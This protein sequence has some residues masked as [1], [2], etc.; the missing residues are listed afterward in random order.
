MVLLRRLEHWPS[1]EGCICSSGS[2]QQKK[3]PSR[4]ARQPAYACS[5]CARPIVWTRRCCSVWILGLDDGQAACNHTESS[6]WDGKRWG[7]GHIHICQTE[8]GDMT[9]HGISR[10]RYLVSS[11]GP[12][13]PCPDRNGK[14][15]PTSRS[16]P[17]LNLQS[18]NESDG[19]RGS[20]PPSPHRQQ[21]PGQLCTRSTF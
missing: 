4:E 8:R 20:P 5:R 13:R 1:R 3:P 11:G 14:E 10:Y 15:T 16:L 7:M 12:C 2:P 19:R 17:F 9:R 18:I 6:R 21:Q